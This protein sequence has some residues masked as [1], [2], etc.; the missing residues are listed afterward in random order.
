MIFA[1]LLGAEVYGIVG[2]LVA[3]PMLAVVRETVVY[4]VEH[5]ELEP[6]GTTEPMTLLA[7]AP[8]PEPCPECGAE[9]AP[10]DGFCRRC[11]EGLERAEVASGR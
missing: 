10:G 9:P 1:L 11:G 4:L 7:G 8:P 2:A 6:W 5:L 3:L